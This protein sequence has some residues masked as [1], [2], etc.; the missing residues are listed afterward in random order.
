MREFVRRRSRWKT[1]YYLVLAAFFCLFSAFFS[2]HSV[3][4]APNYV[5]LIPTEMSNNMHSD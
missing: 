4:V 1:Q 3:Y 5:V 2:A